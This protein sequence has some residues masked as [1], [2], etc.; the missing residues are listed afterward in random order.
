MKSNQL[1]FTYIDQLVLSNGFEI[2]FFFFFGVQKYSI[3]LQHLLR[4]A[5]VIGILPDKQA[6]KPVANPD[7]V[8]AIFDA[9]LEMFLKVSLQ[10]P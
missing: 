3:Y 1:F 8:E 4:V 5:P 9:P 10:F 7:E 2:Y 6:F